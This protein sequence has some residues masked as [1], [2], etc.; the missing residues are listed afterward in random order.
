MTVVEKKHTW[1]KGLIVV[2]D[3]N[4]HLV[5]VYQDSTGAKLVIEKVRYD[6]IS[7]EYT[8]R[9]CLKKSRYELPGT[10]EVI[11]C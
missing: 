1:K 2:C 3:N 8:R 6:S 9:K 10:N 11:V 4:F 7:N 5:A